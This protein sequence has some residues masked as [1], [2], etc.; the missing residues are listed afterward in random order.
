MTY[1]LMATGL[2]VAVVVTSVKD[3]FVLKRKAQPARFVELKGSV[4]QVCGL[5][6]KIL[7]L[8]TL[9]HQQQNLSQAK[10]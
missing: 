6:A 9:R 8:C 3:P 5:N 2:T 7:H 4:L 10:R 1:S